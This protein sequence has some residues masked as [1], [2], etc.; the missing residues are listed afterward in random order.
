MD[1]QTRLVGNIQWFNQFFD[2]VYRL[3]QRIATAL[4]KELA[5]SNSGF[6]YYR[7]NNLPQVPPYYVVGIG[8]DDTFAVQVI[9]VLDVALLENQPAFEP[10]VSFI[11]VK[12]P[13][14]KHYLHL[15]GYGM[16][17]IR[18]QVERAPISPSDEA[19]PFISG[20]IAEG[21]RKGTPFQA[22]QVPIEAFVVGQNVD[23][24]IQTRIVDLL[25]QLPD[26]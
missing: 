8:G 20:R 1:D 18:N 21:G 7:P 17:I 12:H 4:R 15:D 14:G 19:R 25:K 11:V 9:L 10:K 13:V 2:D 6:F 16:R 26:L 3:F 23:E 24:A 22:F 5:L